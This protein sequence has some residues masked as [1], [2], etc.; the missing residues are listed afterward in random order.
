M[1]LGRVNKIVEAKFGKR[2]DNRPRGCVM[3]YSAG[4]NDIQTKLFWF[5]SGIVR[6]VHFIRQWLLPGSII[7]TDCWRVYS[8]LAQYWFDHYQSQIFVDLATQAHTNN[9]ESKWH[10]VQSSITKYKLRNGHFVG[11]LA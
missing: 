2:K 8:N 5:P 3:G 9:T 7:V 1:R 11:Y 6:D 10:D 4:S